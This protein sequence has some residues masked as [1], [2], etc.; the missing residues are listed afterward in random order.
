MMQIETLGGE[1]IGVG[2]QGHDAVLIA[3][4]DPEF[5]RI[6]TVRLGHRQA[7]QLA[8]AIDDSLVAAAGGAV[9]LDEV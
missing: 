5:G 4:T 7:A 3:V 9:E 2:R 8:D 1:E 6:A